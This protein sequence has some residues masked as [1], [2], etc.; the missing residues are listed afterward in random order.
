MGLMSELKRRNVLRMAIL[1]VVAAW[2][3]MQVSE[4][5]MSLINLPDWI[6]PTILGLIAVGFPIALILSW[7]YELTP[8]GFTLETDVDPAES[9]TH[10]TGRRLDF[11]VISM[12][13]AAVILFALDKWWSF[14]P[15]ENSDIPE[16]LSVLL[17]D[18]DNE[19]G[20]DVFTG[21][22]EKATSLVLEDASFVSIMRRNA[23]MM[24][25]KH[26][27]QGAT[28]LGQE[29]ARL[30]ARR[31]GVHVVITG[32][33][34]K[35]DENYI[36]SMS[37]IDAVSG[38]IVSHEQMQTSTREQVLNA[39]GRLAGETR[40]KLGDT[41]S[42]AIRH[43]AE[44]TFTASSLEAVHSYIQATELLT[45][46][47]WLEAAEEFI[48]LAEENP[49]MGR[50][51]AGAA[52]ALANMNR[53]EEA[54]KYFK[55]AMSHVEHMTEREKFRTRGTY[56]LLTRNYH[57]ASEAYENLVEAYPYD[58]VSRVNLALTYFYGRNMDHALIA[59]REAE[60][61]YPENAI[62]Q[63]NHGLIAMYAGDFETAKSRL[64]I[65]LD[66]NTTYET[67]YVGLA[68]S[69]LALGEWLDAKRTY[70]ELNEVSVFGASLAAAGLADLALSKGLYSDACEILERAAAVDVE[71]GDKA[72]AGRK[73]STLAH[74]ELERGRLN[75]AIAAAKRALDLSQQAPILFEAAQ[76]LIGAG[77]QTGAAALALQLG[78]R[79]APEPLAY[80]KLIEGEIAIANGKARDAVSLFN[81]AQ[82]I[83]DTWLGRVN[84]GRAYI[85][86]G[87][88]L[89]AHAEFEAA[90]RRKGEA[91]SI[92]LDD[93]PTHR[94]LPPLHYWLGRAL[95]GLSS[96]AALDSYNNFL[97][98]T[99]EGEGGS[100]ATD[101]HQ[102][103]KSS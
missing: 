43:A 50:A 49:E 16:E 30:V 5:V 68:L 91:L 22:L 53:R 20:D 26:I 6:G 3:I 92:F 82:A 81:E 12:L 31:E 46:G 77:D 101:A 1:Y 98:I 70:H 67:A 87:E 32:S 99:A 14:G 83:L 94:Y 60:E 11:I 93:L 58:E 103:I 44:D 15:L 85:D 27:H 35:S 102:R 39:V 2:L 64:E 45:G 34:K 84:L 33:I 23:A 10:I 66:T 48:A 72:A 28:D 100:L 73:F 17:A 75:D 21:V 25:A 36:V 19:T 59:A 79:I 4:V 61:A 13:S 24:A 69:H 54:A 29:L 74:A 65:F 89:E 88:F 62:A 56:Y 96:P 86:R 8:G 80:A 18:F 95:E 55:L 37:A 90:L 78:E 51:Y 40:K 38:D 7:F 57:K 9:I 71:N 47:K 42:I 63:A 97:E 76:V 52:T 41:N